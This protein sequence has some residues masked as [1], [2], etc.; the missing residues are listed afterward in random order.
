[1]YGKSF[2]V[3]ATVRND[4]LWHSFLNVVFVH[5][6]LTI[7]FCYSLSYLLLQEMS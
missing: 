4:Y 2:E 3:F 6:P 1:M 5:I 7:L